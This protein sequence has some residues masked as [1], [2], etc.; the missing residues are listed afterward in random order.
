MPKCPNGHR[1]PKNQELCSVCDA[2]MV[3]SGK[4]SLSGRA[5]WLIIATSVVAAVIL[6]AVLG[7]IVAHRPNTDSSATSTAGNTALQQWWS[8]AREHFKDLQDAVDGTREGLKRLD[9]AV[10]QESCQ[11]MHDAGVVDLRAHLPAPDPDLTAE[12]DAAINDAHE[13]AHMCLAAANGS[14]NNYFGE[15]AANLDQV[16]IHL[17]AALA[18]INKSALTA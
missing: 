4:R 9:E 11:T 17:Q 2:L 6:V 12:I 14:L 7:A 13:A 15:F 1:N 16:D 18:I 5:W 3:P 8:T 10:L